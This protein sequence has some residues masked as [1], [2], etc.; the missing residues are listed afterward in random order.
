MFQ[1]VIMT[2]C[3]YEL[4]LTGDH[5]VA[6]SLPLHQQD[7]GE[8]KKQQKGYWLGSRQGDRIPI[9]NRGKTDLTWGNLT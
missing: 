1:F 7:S 5:Q 6:L 4:T 2:I 9:T 8:I 3:C